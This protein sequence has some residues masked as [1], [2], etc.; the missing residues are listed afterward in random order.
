V[1]PSFLFLHRNSV[2]WSADHIR[3]LDKTWPYAPADSELHNLLPCADHRNE[4]I[5]FLYCF[6]SL[7]QCESENCYIQLRLLSR[8]WS[9]LFFCQGAHQ[10]STLM[11]PPSPTS[12]PQFAASSKL[13]STKKRLPKSLH[14]GPGFAV[15]CCTLKTSSG[16]A[17]AMRWV[18]GCG[19]I[20]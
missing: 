18:C 12:V 13:L 2:G 1:S 16:G 14:P 19:A 17:I 3:W 4:S 11:P 20:A 15:F 6:T 5:P 7:T 10:F 9:L 8:T